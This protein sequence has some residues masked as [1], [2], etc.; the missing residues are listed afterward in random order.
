MGFGLLHTLDVALAAEGLAQGLWPFEVLEANEMP[1][2]FGYCVS[3]AAK[4]KKPL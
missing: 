4:H 1:Q 3:P 2:R